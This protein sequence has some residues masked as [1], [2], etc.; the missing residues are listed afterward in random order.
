MS[1]LNFFSKCVECKDVGVERCN[2]LTF[3]AA[4]I[5][6]LYQYTARLLPGS[7]IDYVINNAQISM[8]DFAGLGSCYLFCYALMQIPAGL[9]TIKYGVRSLLLWSIPISVIASIL[10]STSTSVTMLYYCTIVHGL[11]SGCAFIATVSA[12]LKAFNENHLPMVF[13]AILSIGSLGGLLVGVPL[14]FLISR[15]GVSG[16]ATVMSFLAVVSFIVLFRFCA[17][18]KDEM[19]EPIEIS[20]CRLAFDKRDVFA[21]AL[22]IAGLCLPIFVFADFWTTTFL[23]VKYEMMRSDAAACASYVFVGFSVGCLVLQGLLG[24]YVLYL[25]RGALAITGV[26][27]CTLLFSEAKP[28]VESV[29]FLTGFFC[30]SLGVAMN[31]LLAGPDHRVALL[32]LAFAN[33]VFFFLSSIVQE[34]SGAILGIKNGDQLLLD[35]SLYNNDDFAVAFSVIL[36]AICMCLCISFTTRK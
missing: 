34:I 33:T 1:V 32:K 13:V 10:S 9:V 28:M 23:M 19:V 11:G 2:Y 36:L 25:S 15:F 24:R 3:F 35:L 17:V 20:N 29:L 22:V 14:T 26:L 5:F 31:R 27:F 7:T 12:A 18:C 8:K 4:L 16:A 21:H 6:Y 30:G